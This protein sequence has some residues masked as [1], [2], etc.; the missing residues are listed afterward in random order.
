MDTRPGLRTQQSR[1]RQAA[2]GQ[3]PDPQEVP[4]RHSVAVSR[5]RRSEE[6][7]HGVSPSFPLH[8]RS[9]AECLRDSAPGTDAWQMAVG[10]KVASGEPS[11][12]KVT[13]A[14]TATNCGSSRVTEPVRQSLTVYVVKAPP[15]V[16]EVRSR[17]SKIGR[18]RGPWLAATRELKKRCLAPRHGFFIDRKRPGLFSEIPSARTTIVARTNGGPN[19]ESSRHSPHQRRTAKDRGGPSRRAFTRILRRPTQK[20]DSCIKAC[21]IFP[22]CGALCLRAGLS[23]W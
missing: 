14:N 9:S 13:N 7:Q 8:A 2:E 1:E 10:R 5:P 20:G 23:P 4:T 18:P 6:A 3:S 22:R 21:G 19:R 16:E 12:P 11:P 17:S 15:R